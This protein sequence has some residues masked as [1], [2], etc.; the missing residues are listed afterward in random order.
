M[1][2]HE[3][4]PN[5]QGLAALIALGILEHF[6]L[7]TLPVD[8]AD[9]I[10]VQAE[11]MKIAFAEAH[12][13]IADPAYMALP[14]E[15]FLAPDYLASRARQIRMDQAASP[16]SALPTDHGTVY[17]TAADAGG[18]MVSFIQSNYFGFGSGIV[19]PAPASRCRIAAAASGWRSGTPIA[20]PAASAPTIPSSPPSSPA[21]GSRCSVSG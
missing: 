14:P 15:A 21:Q 18:M 1:R 16:R 4:P 13:H 3:I 6:P 5:G 17:L 10:H 11:A 7:E 12:R 19:I 9:S 20:W 8:S 2:L